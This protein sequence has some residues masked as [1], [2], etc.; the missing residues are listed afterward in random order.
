MNA[1][2]TFNSIV[3]KKSFDENG[4]SKRQATG[5]GINTPDVMLIKSQPYIDSE[6]K[7]PGTRYNVRVDY[8]GIDANLVKFTTSAYLVIAVPTNA[9]AGSITSV[10]ASFKAMVADTDLIANVLNSET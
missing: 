10:I 4:G 8:V 1:D 9:S 5:R 3:F 7:I 2:L 6:T